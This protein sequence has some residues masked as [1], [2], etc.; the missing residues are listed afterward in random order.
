[1]PRAKEPTSNVVPSPDSVARIYH[2]V[3]SVAFRKKKMSRT[4]NIALPRLDSH[5]PVPAHFHAHLTSGGMTAFAP[6][7]TQAG[8]DE[9]CGL[10]SI[11]SRLREPEGFKTE[12]TMQKCC[13]PAIMEKVILP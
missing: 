13:P 11:G 3:G 1:M 7:G 6:W 4:H 9:P 2:E 5:A 8:S 12:S 10:I